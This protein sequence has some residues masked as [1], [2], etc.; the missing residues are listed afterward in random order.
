[1][2]LLGPPSQRW[3]G[4]DAVLYEGVMGFASADL[5]RQLT[6]YQQR[7]FAQRVA[8]SGRYALWHL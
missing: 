7:C 6:N 8:P 5:K 3:E 2:E 4:F 1:M